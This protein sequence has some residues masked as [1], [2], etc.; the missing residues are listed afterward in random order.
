M[1]NKTKQNKQSQSHAH[2]LPSI[3]TN[4]SETEW[5]AGGG[6]WN[7][8]TSLTLQPGQSKNFTLRLTTAPS[9][10]DVDATLLAYNRPVANAVPGYILT[11][12][13]TSATLSIERHAAVSAAAAAATGSAPPTVTVTP[14]DAL[15]INLTATTTTSL[16]MDNTTLGSSQHV[17]KH[18]PR[19]GGV[20]SERLT[21]TVHGYSVNAIKNG[22]ARVVFTFEDGTDLVVQYYVHPDAAA[23]VK[24]YS[25]A[26][27]TKQWYTDRADPFFRAPSYLNFDRRK[28]SA[29]V[30]PQHAAGQKTERSYGDDVNNVNSIDADG[31][32]ILQ[33]SRAWIAG[34]ETHF[35]K[36]VSREDS[37]DGGAP[38]L[39]SPRLILAYSA[40]ELCILSN[41]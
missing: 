26:L 39:V 13:M 10:R 2:T 17:H 16:T 9:L 4:R 27:S 20:G 36:Y 24:T 5:S 31:G 19:F 25:N 28:V 37:D 41:L 1:L 21:A 33:E 7:P 15:V 8:G 22:R 23:H 38:K 18:R 11:P 29:T 12:T 32:V 35:F 40:A 30:A 3:K 14:A 34:Y 6:P